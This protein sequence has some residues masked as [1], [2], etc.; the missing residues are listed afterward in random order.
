MGR[1]KEIPQGM[2]DA[3]SD[4]RLEAVVH[5]LDEAKNAQDVAD[6]ADT[7]ASI[8]ER[9]GLDSDEID[10]VMR[11]AQAAIIDTGTTAS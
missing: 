2:V 5:K 4:E 6:V 7:V 8:R 10:V 9:W 3:M 1:N 11:M